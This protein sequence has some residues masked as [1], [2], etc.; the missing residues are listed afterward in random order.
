M[1]EELELPKEIAKADQA[2]QALVKLVDSET[3]DRPP[4]EQ[5]IDAAALALNLTTFKF[6]GPVKGF[7]AKQII[8]RHLRKL[9]IVDVGR[10]QLAVAESNITDCMME[11]DDMI[12]GTVDSVVR[13][14]LMALKVKLNEQLINIG[15]TSIKGTSAGGDGVV[16]P[17]RPHVPFPIGQPV[18]VNVMQSNNT[19]EKEGQ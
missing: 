15:Q 5:E 3:E 17:I 2:E 6:S 1:A 18:Q 16:S 14:G 12:A 11:I 4:T 10:G 7:R 8:G 19:A 13:M 9:G